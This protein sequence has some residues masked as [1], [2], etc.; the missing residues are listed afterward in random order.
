MFGF[1]TSPCLASLGEVTCLVA[2]AEACLGKE[3]LARAGEL[4]WLSCAR[5]VAHARYCTRSGSADLGGC[6]HHGSL[7]PSQ[8]TDGNNG[9][10]GSLELN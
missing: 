7:A 1:L 8:R 10:F 9:P 2:A 4:N 3:I 5:K 6:P